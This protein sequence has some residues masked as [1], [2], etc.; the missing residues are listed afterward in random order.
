MQTSPFTAGSIRYQGYFVNDTFQV[1]Q[2]LTLTLGVRWEIP[3]VYTERFDRLVTFD[4]NLPNPELQGRTINGQPVKGAFVLVD[5]P[6]HPERG[7][8]PEH[9]KLFA[10]RV[11]VAY[12][13]S[14]KTVIRTGGGIFYIPATVQFPE[15]P[16]GNVVN[17]L[18][19]VM[20]GTVNNNATPQ[21][22]LSDPFPGGFQAPPGR[23]P[24]LPEGAA[25]RQQSRP[26]AITRDYGYTEQWNFSAAAPAGVGP[27]A[28]SRLR[29][30]SRRAS[31]AGRIPTERACRSSISRWARL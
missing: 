8:R 22:T 20:V 24:S 1:T 11:G 21:N 16:Y 10:P 9:F 14:R 23:N 28:G 12:R 31:S 29:R 18:T 5:T 17:Y 15:G 3:G 19:H 26:A 30:P 25:R 7:L 27:G 6:G 13:L 4:P 2:K